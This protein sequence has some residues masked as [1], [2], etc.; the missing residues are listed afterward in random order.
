MSTDENNSNIVRLIRDNTDEIASM[1]ALLLC[2]VTLMMLIL[3]IILPAMSNMQYMVYPVLIKLAGLLSIM[4]AACCYVADQYDRRFT[5]SAETLFFALF[6]ILMVISTVVNG[7]TRDAVLGVRY[8]YVGVYDI[9]LFITVYM[10]CTAHIRSEEWKNRILGIY[11][12]VADCIAIAFIIDELFGVI[13]AFHGMLE[14]GAI[15]F[16][17]NHYGY[18]MTIAILISAGFFL[19]RSGK[20]MMAGAASLILNL[21]ALAFN[22]TM[23]AFL[24]SGAALMIFAVYA[25]VKKKASSWKP[26]SIIL[27]PS[28][29]IAVALVLSSA[30][31]RDI[32][33]ILFE[34]SE[35]ASGV[36]DMQA[37]N[38]RW[39][40]WQFTLDLIALKPLLGYGCEGI[41]VPFRLYTLTESPHNEVLTYAVYFGIP[42][43]LA[44]TAGVITSLIKGIR[45]GS[46]GDA[47]IIAVFA[48]M[49]Y[50]I[51]SLL[52]VAFFYTAPFFFVMLGLG[53]SREESIGD[54]SEH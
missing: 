17:G 23:G 25:I 3:D 11:M 34:L 5:A 28:F 1:P 13:P 45:R 22:R 52:G 53:V 50:F 40:I 27:I 14:P 33:E 38:G 9:I 32:S 47:G 12:S 19:L 43:A 29:I 4:C 20:L 49:S 24:A 37:G 35:L 2:A 36:N 6:I 21:A 54:K 39:G 41:T 26:W 10:Y 44:Y 30:L 42:A 48:A 51:S 15:F 7:M 16:H 18:Y 8:R 31:R 46:T